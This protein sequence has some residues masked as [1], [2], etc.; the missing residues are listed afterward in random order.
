[1]NIFFGPLVLM[2]PL[3]FLLASLGLT[4]H[5]EATLLDNCAQFLKRRSSDLVGLSNIEL[6]K[7]QL[8][9]DAFSSA[10]HNDL[11]ETFENLYN[12]ETSATGRF[13]ISI[14]FLD[15]LFQERRQFAKS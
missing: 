15:R 9:Q 13:A 3:F 5:V 1:M 12:N 4:A 7:Y 11:F 8:A 14:A 10:S 6:N 2:R